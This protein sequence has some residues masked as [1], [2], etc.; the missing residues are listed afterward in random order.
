MDAKTKKTLGSVAGGCGC[1]LSLALTAWLAFVVYVGLEGRGN[2]EEVSTI[3]G[4]V[5]CCVM[6]PVLLIT[7]A[8][9]VFAFK[10]PKPGEGG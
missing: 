5:T 8:G 10:K 1:L 3:I 4:G 6:V 2:D 7:I 9:F